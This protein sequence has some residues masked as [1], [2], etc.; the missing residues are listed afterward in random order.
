MNFIRTATLVALLLVNI[1]GKAGDALGPRLVLSQPLLLLALNANDTHIALTSAA[2]TSLLAF[3]VSGPRRLLEDLL[4]F[5]AGTSS[6]LCLL[7][8]QTVP[9]HFDD[10]AADHFSSLSSPTG[11]LF[12]EG[13]SERLKHW[14]PWADFGSEKTKSV[15]RRRALPPPFSGLCWSHRGEERCRRLLSAAVRPRSSL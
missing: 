3:A 6:A 10:F 1:V 2:L 4:Y 11:L 14:V 13:A 12:G 9:C 5:Y 7:R 15:V 8:A